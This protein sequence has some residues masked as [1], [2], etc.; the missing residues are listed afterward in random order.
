ML[1]RGRDRHTSGFTLIELLVVIAIIAILAALLL[2]ALASARERGQRTRCISNLEPITIGMTVYAMDN[3][4]KVLVAR[5]GLVQLA[6]EPIDA[7]LASTVGLTVNSTPPGIWSCADRPGLPVYESF[8]DQ[9]TIGYQ[10]FGGIPE[11]E[12]PAGTFTSCSPV[13][14]SQAKPGWCMAADAILKINGSWGGVDTTGGSARETYM[15]MPQH[16]NANSLVPVGGNET[17]CDGSARWVKFNQM[18]YLHT[19]STDGDR[20]AYF[21]QDDIGACNTAAIRAQLA[22][23]P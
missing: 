14:L 13:K 3:S 20:I 4:D 1:R 21:Y 16:H 8:Y 17:F 11:W 9:W 22:A 5:E 23:K 7:A 18:L 19:W 10:Y 15:N 2:P 6:L 12:N